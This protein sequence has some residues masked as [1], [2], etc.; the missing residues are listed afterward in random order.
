MLSRKET[1]EILQ[2]CHNNI[3]YTID[4][5]VL[6]FVGNFSLGYSEWSLE[7]HVPGI[8]NPLLLSRFTLLCM[9]V[10]KLCL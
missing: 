7:S 8:K 2:K 10:Q 6:N 5:S 1:S 9:P 3:Y 4:Q